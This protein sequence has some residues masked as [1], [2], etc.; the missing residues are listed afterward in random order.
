MANKKFEKNEN[1]INDEILLDD[2]DLVRIVGNDGQKCCTFKEAKD[3]A[4]N[5]G[6]DLIG[7]NLNVTPPILKKEDYGKYLYNLKKNS[8]K[9]KPKPLKEIDLRVNIAS[10]DLQTKANHAKDFIRDGSKVKVVLTIKGRENTRLDLSR[11]TL[12]DFIELVSD[13]AVPE[14]APK[15]EGNKYTVILKKK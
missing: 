4:E 7:I 6:L 5:E 9:I 11:Q 1:P 2:N 8:K 3:A 14:T 13:V 15:T 12:F 10:N